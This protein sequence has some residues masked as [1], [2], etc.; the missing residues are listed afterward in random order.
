MVQIVEIGF[1]MA[2][3][4]SNRA[5]RSHEAMVREIG[6]LVGWALGG[7]EVNRT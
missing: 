3:W 2:N 4:T 1:T 5:R 6:G 7:W